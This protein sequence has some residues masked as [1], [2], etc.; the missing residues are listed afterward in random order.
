MEAL[1]VTMVRFQTRSSRFGNPILAS[2]EVIA[3]IR[4]LAQAACHHDDMM[5]L[6]D[7]GLRLECADCGH[8]TTGVPVEQLARRAR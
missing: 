6:D 8:Q 4:E 5:P 2:A 7:D 3:S 1:G